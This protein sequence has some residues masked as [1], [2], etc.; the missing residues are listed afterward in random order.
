MV[1]EDIRDSISE[2]SESALVFDNPAF[3]LSIIGVTTDDRVVYSLSSMIKELSE[4]DNISV[5]EAE[6]FIYYNTIR[7]LDYISAE[8]RPI[9][10]EV[11][12]L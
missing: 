8:Q 9:I 12:N 3:D 5:E 11:E 6:D 4:E 10:I 2:I 7:A 1:K